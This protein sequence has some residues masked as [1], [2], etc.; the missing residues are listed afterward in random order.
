VASV[1]LDELVEHWTVLEDARALVGTK[2]AR[3]GWALRCC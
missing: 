1:D 2:R 3:R